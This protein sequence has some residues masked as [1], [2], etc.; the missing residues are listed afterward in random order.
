VVFGRGGDYTATGGCDITEGTWSLRG[1]AVQLDPTNLITP[2][3]TTTEADGLLSNVVGL[4]EFE[5]GA[6]VFG[7]IRLRQL[8][9]LPMVRAD[10]LVG[11]WNAGGT[12]VAFEDDGRVVLGA[13]CARL[14]W[15][16]DAS[17]LT[18]DEDSGS[19]ELGD[20]PLLGDVFAAGGVV[21]LRLD[22]DALY[23]GDG[24]PF[25]LR[26]IPD[27]APPADPGPPPLHGVE[28]VAELLGTWRGDGQELTIAP[29]VLEV[30]GCT[31]AWTLENRVLQTASDVDL[32]NLSR[33]ELAVALLGGAFARTDGERLVLADANQVIELQRMEDQHA[34]RSL[35]E[36]LLLS[37]YEELGVDTCCQEPPEG[38]D[39]GLIGFVWE[40]QP[41]GVVAAP[42]DEAPAPR[43]STHTASC[44]GY[45]VLVDGATAAA[46]ALFGVLDCVGD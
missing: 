17:S 22:G 38:R 45:R 5:D 11:R 43:A 14:R 36:R 12:E 32:C 25:V 35:A 37:A 40:G 44:G 27:D 42:P 33:N 16:L 9:S 30:D 18:L 39:W 15:S 29:T 6:L 19:C 10:D 2:F 26:R 21:P 13:S 31:Y 1:D 20:P 28:D 4:G 3:C 34:G 23:V 7:S 46:E 8:S 24:V 41:V